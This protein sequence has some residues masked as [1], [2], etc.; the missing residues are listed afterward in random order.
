MEWIAMKGKREEFWAKPGPIPSWRVKELQKEFDLGYWTARFGIYGPLKIVESKRDEIQKLV[1]ARIPTGRLKSR[2]FSGEHG[3]PLKAEDV[4]PEEGG[5]F[6]GVPSLWSLPM[7]QYRLPLKGGGIA[8]HIDYSPIIP[9]SGKAVL[10]WA[11][12]SQK[13]CEE[14][15]FELFCDFFMHERHVIFVNF[16]TFDKTNL[17]HRDSIRTI[18]KGL[19]KEGKTRGYSAYRTHIN[20]MGKLGRSKDK[21]LPN[22]F[23][24]T[25]LVIDIISD[26]YDF[27]NHAYRRF[28]EKIKVSN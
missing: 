16:M 2:I 3:K 15:G 21:L 17:N 4:P 22:S 13:I 14:N 24:K 28:V 1:Q 25:N 23:C 11:K 6:V 7:V 27:N 5:F 19:F 26:F 10:E 8:G 12:A 18:F 20:F 9:S